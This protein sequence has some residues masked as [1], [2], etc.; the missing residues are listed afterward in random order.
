[1]GAVAAATGILEFLIK[2]FTYRDALLLPGLTTNTELVNETRWGLERIHGPASHPI[3]CGLPR[4]VWHPGPSLPPTRKELSPAATQRVALL[5]ICAVTPMT[6]ARR[7]CGGGRWTCL[8]CD[9]SAQ[10]R[11]TEPCDTRSGWSRSKSMKGQLLI[12]ED[13]PSIAGRTADYAKIPGLIAGFEAFGRGLGTFDP[14]LYFYLDNQYLGSLLE[15][16][17]WA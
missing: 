6:V 10:P 5:L 2:G 13:D 1:M 4:C 14:T 7:A 15:E 8:L 12:G 16:G 3:E 9:A 17:C 11:E